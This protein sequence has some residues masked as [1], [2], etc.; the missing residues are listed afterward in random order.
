MLKRYALTA[1]ALLFVAAL[2]AAAQ[3]ADELYPV[4]QPT[5]QELEYFDLDPDFY[6]KACLTQDILI[7]TSENVSDFAI[8]ETAYLYDMIMSSINPEVAQRIRDERVLC[9]LIGANELTS[10]L[11]QYRTDLT[12][13]ELDFYNWRRRGFLA[14]LNI[15]GRRQPV[16]VFAEEDVM[17]YPGGAQ[18]ESILIHEFGHVVMF[19]GF[20]EAQMEAVTAAYANAQD[21]GIFMDG[22]PCQ[23]FRRVTGETL[24]SVRG[25][26]TYCRRRHCGAAVPLLHSGLEGECYLF[27]STAFFL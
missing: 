6:T 3:D 18:D 25:D 15:D 27:E 14:R 20:S 16:V 19:Q 11:P 7:A 5:A 21:T 22:Y 12:G 17:E 10:D 24:G 4:R 13:E 9:L 23:R 8:M 2:P 26:A 1:L